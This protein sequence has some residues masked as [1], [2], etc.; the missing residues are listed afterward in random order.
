MNG[1]REGG[2]RG[3]QCCFILT[4][5][6]WSPPQ[7]NIHVW[8]RSFHLRSEKETQPCCCWR[9]IYSEKQAVLS[10]NRLTRR[11]GG[12]ECKHNSIFGGHDVFFCDEGSQSV[13]RALDPLS[14]YSVQ[15]TKRVASGRRAGGRWWKAHARD[16]KRLVNKQN[17]CLRSALLP[18]THRVYPWVWILGGK[19]IK[20]STAVFSN[21][22]IC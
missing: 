7:S 12:S 22:S 11:G 21:G 16:V 15:W 19:T 6:E 20:L 18:K 17:L 3:R 8:P 10:E 13:W 4:G 14:V 1:C 2:G 9:R 5:S